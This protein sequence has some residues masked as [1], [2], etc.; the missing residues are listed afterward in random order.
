MSECSFLRGKE[1][2]LCRAE[3]KVQAGVKV[4]M[5]SFMVQGVELPPPPTIIDDAV[6]AVIGKG[7]H[8]DRLGRMKQSL[9]GGEPSTARPSKAEEATRLRRSQ[10]EYSMSESS[11]KVEGK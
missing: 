4:Y 3:I 1:L 5:L 6:D 11:T 9:W 10:F 2:I 7:K 8:A